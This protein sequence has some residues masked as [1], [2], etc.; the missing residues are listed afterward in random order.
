MPAATSSRPGDYR[1]LLPITWLYL[2]Q[3]AIQDNLI[4]IPCVYYHYS[5]YFTAEYAESG[6]V[7]TDA[8]FNSCSQVSIVFWSLYWFIC[9]TLRPEGECVYTRE[10]PLGDCGK[11]F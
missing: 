4:K 9:V 8:G 6:K 2:F 3:A 7:K 10:S 5:A 1:V 11:S